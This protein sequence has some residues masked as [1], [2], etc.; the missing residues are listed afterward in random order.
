M[1]PKFNRDYGGMQ[2]RV[3]LVREGEVKP[4]KISDPKDVYDLV[5]YELASADREMLLSV[6]LTSSN[7]LIGVEI[8]SVGSLGST[9]TSPREVFKSA[10]LGN[11]NSI[12]LCHNHPSGSLSPSSCDYSITDEMVKA[13]KLLGVGVA[14]HII[15]SHVGYKS[16]R[17]DDDYQISW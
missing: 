4:V 6:M 13:G 9:Q 3:C 15:V 11:A 7:H 17:E 12:I 5:K 14:D 16:L 8:V 10:I 1:K 2:C